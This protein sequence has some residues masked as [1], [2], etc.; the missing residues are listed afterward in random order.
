MLSGEIN[1]KTDLRQYFAENAKYIS[2][3]YHEATWWIPMDNSPDV[4]SYVRVKS[5]LVLKNLLINNEALDPNIDDTSIEGIPHDFYTLLL[6][7]IESAF[8]KGKFRLT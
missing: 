2:Q 8:N 7:R 6:S 3:M 4:A 5:E 1:G